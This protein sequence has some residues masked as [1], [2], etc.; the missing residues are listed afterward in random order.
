[1]VNLRIMASIQCIN[2]PFSAGP[3]GSEEAIK[4][5][6]EKLGCAMC[7][8]TDSNDRKD[9]VNVHVNVINYLGHNTM[10]FN[11]ALCGLCYGAHCKTTEDEAMIK[12][13]RFVSKKGMKTIAP[14]NHT[15]N[16]KTLQRLITRN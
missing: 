9:L 16:Y 10:Y 2:V 15:P 4:R 8:L 6:N 5:W 7:G 14:K 12:E 3:E 11:T 13:R 1:M